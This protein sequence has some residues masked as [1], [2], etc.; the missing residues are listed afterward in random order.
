MKVEY[1]KLLPI[2]EELRQ[3]LLKPR[4]RVRLRTTEA[5]A[6]RMKYKAD[7]PKKVRVRCQFCNKRFTPKRSTKKFC[8]PVCRNKSNTRETKLFIEHNIYSQLFKLPIDKRKSKPQI[9]LMRELL[10]NVA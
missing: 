6:R 5:I 7:K 3:E 4:K 8:S 10:R 1:I 9:E 2:S